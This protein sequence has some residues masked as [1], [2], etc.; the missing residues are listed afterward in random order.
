MQTKRKP[1]FLGCTFQNDM[2]TWPNLE[3]LPIPSSRGVHNPPNTDITL[4]FCR[5]VLKERR[6][7]RR[8]PRNILP[9]TRTVHDRGC[10]CVLILNQNDMVKN[11]VHVPM[12]LHRQ[13]PIWFSKLFNKGSAPKKIPV[14]DMTSTLQVHTYHLGSSDKGMLP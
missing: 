10:L 1:P 2:D 14:E 9:P 3:F 4:A 13:H 6:G 5:P 11:Q 8:V 7:G 12:H